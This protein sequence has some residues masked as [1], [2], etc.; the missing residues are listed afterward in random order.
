MYTNV[1]K[2][3]ENAQKIQ[4]KSCASSVRIRTVWLTKYSLKAATKFHTSNPFHNRTK[5]LLKKY[6]VTLPQLLYNKEERCFMLVNFN[7]NLVKL[8]LKTVKRT[9]FQLMQMFLSLMTNV[10]CL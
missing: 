10:S 5:Y 8:Q 7:S 1:K 4:R 2:Y 9:N 6:L 3:G